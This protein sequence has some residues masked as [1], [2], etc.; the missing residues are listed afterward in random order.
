MASSGD[1]EEQIWSF[2]EDRTQQCQNSMESI[3]RRRAN[4]SVDDL[5]RE[6][7]REAERL[8]QDITRRIDR[9]KDEVKSRRPTDERRSD[10]EQRLQQYRRFVTSAT[11]GI[12]QTAMRIDRL[13]ERLTNMVRR[14]VQWITDR[15][16]DIIRVL[17]IIRA[18]FREIFSLIPN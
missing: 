6:L 9:I 14:I 5:E 15:G 4:Q 18:T 16:N 12:Q 10:Y 8:Q 7:D 13:I 3:A 1:Y 2:V 11:T 17:D